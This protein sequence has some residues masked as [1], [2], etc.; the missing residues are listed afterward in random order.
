MTLL[1]WKRKQDE[2]I[3]TTLESTNRT[4]FGD[5]RVRRV[6]GGSLLAE[7]YF[8]D[9][10]QQEDGVFLREAALSVR[11]GLHRSWNELLL[12]QSLLCK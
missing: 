11:H 6:G 10:P 8:V 7:A 9:V 4:F 1:A 2:Q 5:S 3:P 12:L